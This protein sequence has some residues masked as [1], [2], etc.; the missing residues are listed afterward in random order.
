RV[1]DPESHST[2][3]HLSPMASVRVGD[4]HEATFAWSPL[5]RLTSRVSFR[6]VSSA[7]FRTGLYPH[8]ATT[9]IADIQTG[10]I[11][12]T[13]RRGNTQCWLS[14]FRTLRPACLAGFGTGVYP[15][16]AT[17][18]IPDIQTGDIA[19]TSR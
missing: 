1:L 7:R 2:A 16:C 11:A 10:D 4:R 15:H 19:D 18:T 12:D 14:G 8:C 9:N 17:T 13:S 3:F 6:P 5:R